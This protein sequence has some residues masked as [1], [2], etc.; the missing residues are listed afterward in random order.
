[1]ALCDEKRLGLDPFENKA[2]FE[3]LPYNS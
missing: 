2:K 3:K 1:M